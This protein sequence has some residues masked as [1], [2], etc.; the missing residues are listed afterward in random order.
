VTCLPTDSHVVYLSRQAK[1]LLFELKELT[2]TSDL[3]VPGRSSLTKPFAANA[4]NKDQS[5]VK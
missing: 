3:V 5:S 2:V 4:P 1:A